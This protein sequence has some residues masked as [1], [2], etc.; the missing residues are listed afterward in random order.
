MEML[1]FY[2]SFSAVLGSNEF[3]SEIKE[4]FMR[5]SSVTRASRRILMRIREEKIEKNC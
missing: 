5:E 3:V 4:K 1:W 2:R